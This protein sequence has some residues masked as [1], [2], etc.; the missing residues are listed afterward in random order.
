VTSPLYDKNKAPEGLVQIG[1]EIREKV[2][3][4]GGLYI[5]LGQPLYNRPELISDDGAHPNDAGHALIARVMVD[6]FRAI[7]SPQLTIG[8]KP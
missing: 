3:A 7:N 8:A 4:V 1:D 2:E 6:H 5:D